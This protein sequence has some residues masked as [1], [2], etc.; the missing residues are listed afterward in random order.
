MAGER[1]AGRLLVMALL[2]LIGFSSASIYF[3]AS[4]WFEANA[5]SGSIERGVSMR[6]LHFSLMVP[7][8]PNR[9]VV[10]LSQFEI[11]NNAMVNIQTTSFFQR[12]YLI[13]FSYSDLV[14]SYY[15]GGVAVNKGSNITITTNSTVPYMRGASIYQAAKNADNWLWIAHISL[16][17]DS[18]D[19]VLY[20]CFSNSAKNPPNGTV[21]GVDL[22]SASC[23]VPQPPPFGSG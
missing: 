18:S 22:P 23:S 21:G 6:W 14:A 12:L 13:V 17:V 19:I 1:V 2:A 16:R 3:N 4:S 7:E 15:F 20:L 9:S 8:N 5:I 10:M 11:T